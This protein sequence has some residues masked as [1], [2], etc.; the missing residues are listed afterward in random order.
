MWS[1]PVSSS[2]S[3]PV[4]RYRFALTAIVESTARYADVPYG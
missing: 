2:R 1:S 3:F 4:Y